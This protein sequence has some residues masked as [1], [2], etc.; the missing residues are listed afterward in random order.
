MIETFRDKVVLKSAPLSDLLR[1]GVAKFTKRGHGRVYAK[2]TFEVP[3]KAALV[4][5]TAPE[6]WEGGD[7]VAG[8]RFDEWGVK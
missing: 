8:K 2:I 7:N 6:Y 1:D 3:V 4:K 5:D